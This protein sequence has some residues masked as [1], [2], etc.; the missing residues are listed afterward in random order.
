MIKDGADEIRNRLSSSVPGSFLLSFLF[1]NWQAVLMLA[2]GDASPADR[3]DQISKFFREQHWAFIWILPLLTAATYVS[4]IPAIKYIYE[5]YWVLRW[6]VMEEEKRIL[7]EQR[8]KDF[9]LIRQP[10]EQLTSHLRDAAVMSSSRI[11]SLV[12]TANAFYDNP[13]REDH[14]RSLRQQMTDAG[15]WARNLGQLI[16]QV[17]K[18]GLDHNHKEPIGNVVDRLRPYFGD[19]LASWKKG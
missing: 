19:Y 5:T 8:K 2:Y 16:E 18:L 7:A 14:R 6:S 1:W 10:L 3:I 9:A 13:A 4:V 17:E 11:S 15:D 12:A